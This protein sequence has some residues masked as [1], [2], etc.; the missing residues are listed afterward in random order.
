MNKQ[1]LVFN[2]CKA[3]ST[4]WAVF[5][6]A[7]I[8]RLLHLASMAPILGY[9]HRLNDGVYFDALAQA[10]VQ[11][12]YDGKM[13]IVGLSPIYVGFL[14]GFYEW[15]GHHLLFPRLGQIFLGSLAC[16]GL[17]QISR[18]LFGERAGWIAGLLASF[19]GVFIYFD[20]ILIKASL[21]NSVWIL[22]LW[23][24]SQGFQSGRWWKWALA[25]AGYAVACML[26]MQLFLIAPWILWIL[27]KNKINSNFKQTVLSILFF[28]IFAMA[29]PVLVGQWFKLSV[30][31]TKNIPPAYEIAAPQLG[32]HFYVGNN[33]AANG[34]YKK[35]DGI[36]ASAVGHV[37]DARQLAEK[38]AGQK[39]DAN[40]LNQ[41]WLRR[42]IESIYENPWRWIQ[43]EAKKFFLIWN[44]YEVA[45]SQNYEYWKRFSFVLR[46]PLVSYGWLAPLALLGWIGL[47]KDSRPM[48]SFLKG[49]AVLYV[50]ALLLTFVTADYRLPLHSI[51]ILFASFSVDRLIRNWQA[52][53][54]D[55]LKKAA[56]LFAV[57]FVFCNYQTHLRKERY[58]SF[59]QKRHDTILNAQQTKEASSV[60][61]AEVKPASNGSAV[62]V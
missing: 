35:V 59:L 51:W 42:G 32:I 49:A 30:E 21:M 8:V 5:A 15:L 40:G 56:A 19:C 60:G 28:V 41:F 50:I 55:E 1:V 2:L 36:R 12:S 53:Q 23:A 52:S 47:R 39:L 45:N 27:F 11:G 57:F 13:P 25:G 54:H 62:S 10:L 17:Q 16:V 18:N 6:S 37:V 44:T 4:A 24:M 22:V 14:S 38:E 34:T 58:D 46:L 61:R 9:E 7:L 43:L 48:I 3:P 26:R 29:V 33:S 31:R 20:A